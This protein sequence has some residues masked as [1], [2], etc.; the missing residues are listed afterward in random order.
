MRL[1]RGCHARPRPERKRVWMGLN[2]GD[3][4]ATGFTAVAVSPPVVMVAARQHEQHQRSRSRRKLCIMVRN[5]D[6]C[7]LRDWDN[8]SGQL[9]IAQPA[10]SGYVPVRIHNKFA[11]AGYRPP[12]VSQPAWRNVSLRSNRR[13][14]GPV[15]RSLWGS[16]TAWN[17][18]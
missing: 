16:A 7:G 9:G 5:S 10:L 12:A 14:R 3:S 8:Q 6:R 17:L 11:H 1:P 18:I 13:L 4:W 15:T 2:V